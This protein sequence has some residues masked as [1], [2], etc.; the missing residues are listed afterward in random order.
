MSIIPAL[1][2]TVM[3][4]LSIGNWFLY[5]TDMPRYDKFRFEGLVAVGSNIVAV[6][7]VEDALPSGG[8]DRLFTL[9][10]YSFSGASATRVW[11]Y[12][13]EGGQWDDDGYA[14]AS[15]WTDDNPS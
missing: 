2:I 12:N 11:Y 5:D 14:I 8:D 7:Y 1:T 3:A 4:T 15:Y 9:R 10:E 13:Y 6:G